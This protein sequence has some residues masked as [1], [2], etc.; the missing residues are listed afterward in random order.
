MPSAA[1][2]LRSAAPPASLD[3]LEAWELA[4]AP[5]NG[6]TQGPSGRREAR[7]R[8]RSESA[9]PPGATASL[10]LLVDTGASRSCVSSSAAAAAGVRGAASVRLR[11]PLGL[12]FD[13][14]IAPLPAGVDGILGFDA[15]RAAGGAVELDFAR[16]ALRVHARERWAAPRGATALPLEVRRVSAGELP[17]VAMRL[18]GGAAGGGASACCEVP[19]VLDTGSPLTMV[20]PEAAAAA[21]LT[22]GDAA[23]DVTTTGVDGQ[24]TPLQAHEGRRALLGGGA[25]ARAPMRCWVGTLPLMQACGL[26]GEWMR[27]QPPPS[28]AGP[29]T[30]LTPAQRTR[31]R[32]PAQR[33]DRA[34]SA[35]RRPGRQSQDRCGDRL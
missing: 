30:A 22:R 10:T 21:G 27:V 9:A 11:S 20:S 14:A 4:W 8:A 31:R 25:V 26:A 12:A 1:A 17:F 24:P 32:R 16:G 23:A 33:A 5:A 34:R 28:I 15:M 6:R 7:F 18:E 29:L 35:V 3:H 2:W 13:C 19:G